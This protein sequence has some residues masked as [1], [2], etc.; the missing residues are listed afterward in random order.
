M[1][2]AMLGMTL[3]NDTTN[4]YNKCHQLS[5]DRK[6]GWDEGQDEC[7]HSGDVSAKPAW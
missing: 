4:I 6:G 2:V 5:V 1:S 3:L 7:M